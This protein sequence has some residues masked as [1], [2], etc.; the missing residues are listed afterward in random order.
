[1]EKLSYSNP[2]KMLHSQPIIFS[3]E[4][5]EEVSITGLAYCPT[6]C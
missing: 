6:Q 2:L 5:G 3:A 1:M 4:T